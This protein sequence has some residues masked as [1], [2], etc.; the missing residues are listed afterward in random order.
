M[1]RL[2]FFAKMKFTPMPIRDDGM[3]DTGLAQA[4]AHARSPAL[5][6]EFIGTS[7][8]HFFA[9]AIARS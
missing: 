4:N 2:M 6:P 8:I 3:K 7:T 9:F 1:I 5:F